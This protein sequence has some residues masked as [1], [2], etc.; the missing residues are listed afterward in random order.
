M[1]KITIFG[2]CRQDSIYNS[3]SV[4]R[5]RDELTYPHYTSEAL[6]AVKFVSGK[7]NKQNLNLNIAFRT[8]LLDGK[9]GSDQKLRNDF[10]NS[11]LFIVEIASRKSY[12][13]E[14]T[15]AHHIIEDPELSHLQNSELIIDFESDDMIEQNILEM[16]SIFEPRPMTLVTHFYTKKSRMR[17]EFVTLLK[18]IG[19]KHKIPVFDPV[20]QFGGC[21]MILES[22]EPEKVL[23]HY[24]RMGHQFVGTKYKEFIESNFDIKPSKKLFSPILKKQIKSR[25][26]T[27]FNSLVNKIK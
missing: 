18:Q 10:R 20:E 9:I 6:Q 4:T 22:L 12:K 2:S 26:M 3:F 23:T 27:R 13:V 8:S 15:F 25:I 11:D 17:Y 21:D 14:D 16:Q 24:N 7:I 1:A 19:E 5:I